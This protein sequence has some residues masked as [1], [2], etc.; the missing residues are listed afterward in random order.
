MALSPRG[1]NAFTS[2]YSEPT[3]TNEPARRTSQTHVN[4]WIT[5]SALSLLVTITIACLYILTGSPAEPGTASA[6]APLPKTRSSPLPSA[7]ST[8]PPR[9]YFASS[10][11]LQ[12][13]EAAAANPAF[14]PADG[15]AAAPHRQTRQ[16]NEVWPAGREKGKRPNDPWRASRSGTV[17]AAQRAQRNQK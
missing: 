8:P 2:I 7:D 13:L 11:P 6:Y 17:F 14:D 9:T 1:R 15:L 4:G 10:R 16:G 12:S 3:M 5:V